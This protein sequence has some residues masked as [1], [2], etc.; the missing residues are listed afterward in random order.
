M[1]F[2]FSLVGMQGEFPVVL[3]YKLAFL[4]SYNWDQVGASCKTGTICNL[5]KFPRHKPHDA[6]ASRSQCASCSVPW[7]EARISKSVSCPRL[8]TPCCYKCRRE[9]GMSILPSTHEKSN[10]SL[11][12]DHSL[13]HLLWGRNRGGE[14]HHLFFRFVYA[15]ACQVLSL[16][17]VHPIS[18]PTML[19]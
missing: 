3:L 4:Q 8:L 13:H 14:I 16:P 11:L 19:N 18:D 9:V 1:Y 17:C 2:V 15:M 7:I 12:L 5:N 10:F 6:R